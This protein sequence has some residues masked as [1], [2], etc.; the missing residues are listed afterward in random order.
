MA[1]S[2][3]KGFGCDNPVE[4]TALSDVQMARTITFEFDDGT[5]MKMTYDAAGDAIPS[6]GRNFQIAGSSFECECEP[7]F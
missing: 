3:T 7:D 6:S 5:C 1:E 4:P 2:T